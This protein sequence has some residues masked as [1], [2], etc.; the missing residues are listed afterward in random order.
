MYTH[1]T[2]KRRG[3]ARGPRAQHPP[4]HKPGFAETIIQNPSRLRSASCARRRARAGPGPWRIRQRAQ[5][6]PAGRPSLML[7]AGRR[8]GAGG[9]AV[10]SV[11][12]SPHVTSPG[13][14]AGSGVHS[15]AAPPG[16]S[17]SVDG[18]DPGPGR[19]LRGAGLGPE[20]TSGLSP[21]PGF[22]TTGV[23]VPRPSPR[24]PTRPWRPLSRGHAGRRGLGPDARSAEE[25]PSAGRPAP[26]P[27]R[28]RRRRGHK[29][30]SGPPPGLEA[31]PHHPGPPPAAGGLRRTL[32]TPPRLP[33][34]SSRRVLRLLSPSAKMYR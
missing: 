28:R 11:A 16:G 6:H 8:R 13:D 2:L 5:C 15:A 26:P 4:N 17:L 30:G 31:P 34:A 27:P 32:A 14:P 3:R 24:P 22:R 18:G 21:P 29:A 9:R 33:D 10:Q 19:R 7:R 12:V 25:R 1:T 20:S 23:G